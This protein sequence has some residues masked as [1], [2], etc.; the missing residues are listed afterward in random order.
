MPI[1]TL[2]G[3]PG[4]PQY[5][6]GDY[7]MVAPASTDQSS[8]L[9]GNPLVV[10][11]YLVPPDA[12][13]GQ[14][15]R[16]GYGTDGQLNPFAA[17]PTGA[18]VIQAAGGHLI[19]TYFVADR[20]PNGDKSLLDARKQGNH[21]YRSYRNPT[22]NTLEGWD[23]IVPGPAQPGVH[24]GLCTSTVL[25]DRTHAGQ[26]STF[27]SDPYDEN[28]LYVVDRDGIKLSTDKGETWRRDKELSDWLTDQG[29]IGPDCK[30]YCGAQQLRELV[31]IEFVPGEPGTRFA[32]GEAGVFFTTEGA[33]A[34]S[35]T[36]EHWHRLLA[37]S[38]LS[39]LPGRSFFAPDDSVGRTLYVSCVGRSLLSFAGIPKPKETID[40]TE[41][42]ISK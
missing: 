9:K 31:S 19:P 17:L 25:S 3:A 33:V 24:N 4:G 7:V 18:V 23:C 14:W 2:P 13:R 8:V 36:D 5:A 21:L 30:V 34:G 38:A 35:R 12:T 40:Y 10:W 29:A 16:E 27:F 20:Q 41:T 11:R 28:V 6:I 15:H 1:L 39:C 42:V 26:A 32:L 22:S 37:T